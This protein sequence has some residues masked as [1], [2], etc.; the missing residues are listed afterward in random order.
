MFKAPA[1]LS[2]SPRLSSELVFLPFHLG[3][4]FN[5]EIVFSFTRWK[6]QGKKKTSSLCPFRALAASSGWYQWSTFLFLR[7]QASVGSSCPLT[8][9]M[10]FKM[11]LG[12]QDDARWGQAVRGS[13]CCVEQPA[14]YF[15]G[16]EVLW[17][18]FGTYL[19]G[20]C[21]AYSWERCEVLFQIGPRA[22]TYRLRGWV[23]SHCTYSGVACSMGSLRVGALAKPF[24]L[25]PPSIV[26]APLTAAF[27][28]PGKRKEN[29]LSELSDIGVA[30]VTATHFPSTI[31]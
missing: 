17:K 24:L 19:L 8:H 9:S 6:R 30:H 21:E 4:R 13:V 26:L 7:C 15:L 5:L 18:V 29:T 20:R 2:P 31:R 28:V 25:H 22:A 3:E 23:S 14:L 1:T 12:M 11:G 27:W 10:S 16:I